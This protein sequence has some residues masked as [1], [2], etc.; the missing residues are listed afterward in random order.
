MK[1]VCWIWVPARSLSH[2]IETSSASWFLSISCCLSH[3][4]RASDLFGY[5][6]GSSPIRMNR[7]KLTYFSLSVPAHTW[8]AAWSTV[9]VLVGGLVWAHSAMAVEDPNKVIRPKDTQAVGQ[10]ELIAG[11]IRGALQA[12]KGHP[13][14]ESALQQLYTTATEQGPIAAQGLGQRQGIADVGGQIQVIVEM[15]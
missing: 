12:K 7:N 3:S 10:Q 1:A 15:E 6:R 8:R 9:A 2:D 13:K 14:L 4:E 11:S 5:P